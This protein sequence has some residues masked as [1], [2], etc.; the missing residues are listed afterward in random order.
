ML[1]P[2]IMFFIT[3]IRFFFLGR[4]L[5]SCSL[6]INKVES[7]IVPNLL[8]FC[9]SLEVK[10]NIFEQEIPIITGVGEG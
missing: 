1:L 2:G 3:V 10:M 9:N 5:T 6:Q 4:E 7:I 8:N